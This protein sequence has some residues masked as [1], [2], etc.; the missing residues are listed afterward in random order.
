MD[1]FKNLARFLVFAFVFVGGAI[2]LAG[3][4]GEKSDKAVLSSAL[5][6]KQTRSGLEHK[7]KKLSQRSRDDLRANR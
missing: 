3:P 4:D 1:S 7:E 5:Q 6:T 2:T